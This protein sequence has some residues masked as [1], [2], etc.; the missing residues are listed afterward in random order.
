MSNFF[1]FAPF[2]VLKTNEVGDSSPRQMYF[3]LGRIDRF[4]PLR[5]GGTE[6]TIGFAYGEFWRLYARKYTVAQSSEE[7]KRVLEAELKLLAA[8]D[9][10]PRQ[11]KNMG[12]NF[13]ARD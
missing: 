3:N 7:V 2:D 10:P 1:M 12:N 5:K 4:D 11:I 6:L 13:G 8:Y 9:F